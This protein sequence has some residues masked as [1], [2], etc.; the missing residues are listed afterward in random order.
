[1]FCQYSFA[2][3]QPMPNDKKKIISIKDLTIAEIKAQLGSEAKGGHDIGN[4]DYSYSIDASHE[5]LFDSILYGAPFSPKTVS[6]G[7]PYKLIKK[8]LK[9]LSVHFPKSAN[10]LKSILNNGSLLWYFVEKEGV[11]LRDLNTLDNAPIVIAHRLEPIAVNTG[12]EVFILKNKFDNMG[13]R[14]QAFLILHELLWPAVDTMS[15]ANSNTM[16]QISGLLLNPMLQKI[17]LIDVFN[18]FQRIFRESNIKA[19]RLAEL[20]DNEYKLQTS[21]PRFEVIEH[22]SNFGVQS[23]AIVKR[24][25]LKGKMIT[26]VNPNPQLPVLYFDDRYGTLS[27]SEDN[28]FYNEVMNNE[29]CSGLKYAGMSSWSLITEDELFELYK[30]SLTTLSYLGLIPFNGEYVYTTAENSLVRMSKRYDII[31]DKFENYT[32][33]VKYICI[34]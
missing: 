30:N 5:V 18:Q 13:P 12:S 8:A 19:S 29:L 6:S 23:Y 33:S 11:K 2:Q 25:S 16:A 26:F 4:H 32:G 22:Y 1:M 15:T 24:G 9:N 28:H 14:D 34:K 31:S 17:R 7:E 27:N 20:I 10:Y 3:K 21:L